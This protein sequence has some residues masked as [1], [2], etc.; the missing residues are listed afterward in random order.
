MLIRI[1]RLFPLWAVA[2]SLLA[3]ARPEWFAPLKPAEFVIIKI[4]QMTGDIET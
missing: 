3:L 2:G 1:T 4:Q